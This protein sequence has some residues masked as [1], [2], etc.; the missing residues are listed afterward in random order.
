MG[1]RVLLPGWSTLWRLV[2]AASE[3]ADERGWSMLA[4]TLTDE[5]RER[6]ERLLHVMAGRRVTDL[7]RLRMAPVEPTIKGLIAALERLRELRLLADGLGGLEALPNARLRVLMVA[8]ER[9]RGGELADLRESRRLATLMAFAI[10]AAR[11]GQ[12][13]ALEHFDR[14]HGDLLLRAAAAGK[15]ERLRDGEAID[16]AG[17]TLARACSVLL[18]DTITE[19]LREVVFAAVERERLAAAVTAIGQLTRSP[20]DRARELVTRS[21]TGVRRY[22]PLLLDTIEF[23]AT[24]GGEAILEALSALNR[25]EGRRKLKPELLPTRFVP[26]PWQPLVEPEPGRID[27]GAY[28]MCALEELRDGLRRRDVYVT[29]SE[30]FAD[31]RSSLLSDAAWDASREDTC[32]ALSLPTS[33]DVFI[34]Q[35]AGE[36]TTPTSAPARDWPQTTRSTPLPA[37]GAARRPARRTPRASIAHGAT[38]GRGPC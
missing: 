15:R 38:R 2:G 26:R 34:Q 37:R 16:H 14:L 11:R 10:T 20:D 5:Q 24:D 18:D 27:R 1:Q 21:Y 33:P 7:E 6:L 12:H 29:P 22:L 25:S 32:R 30:R 17:R 28:T 8:A 4:A 31:A 36:L 3:S 23:H 35:L 9:Q 13:D 19:P